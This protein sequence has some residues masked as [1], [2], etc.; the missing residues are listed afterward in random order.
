MQMH[1]DTYEELSLRSESHS[2]G[3]K[4]AAPPPASHPGAYTILVSFP[5]PLPA[6]PEFQHWGL[7]LGA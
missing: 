2:K 5:D 3:L 7:V 6:E 1:A 4:L